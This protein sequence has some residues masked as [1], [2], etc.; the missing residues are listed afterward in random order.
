MGVP[1]GEGGEA[2]A[3]LTSLGPEAEDPAEPCGPQG[4]S[5]S[6]PDISF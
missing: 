4:K 6:S 3:T 1:I 2:T 5:D